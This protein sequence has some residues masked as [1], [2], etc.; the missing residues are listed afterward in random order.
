MRSGITT[1]RNRKRRE[2]PREAEAQTARFRGRRRKRRYPGRFT[3]LRERPGRQAF[4]PF[5]SRL[6]LSVA[7]G[8]FITLRT[9]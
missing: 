6:G 8:D 3:A 7:Q 9:E 4:P 5:A 2:V 1:R